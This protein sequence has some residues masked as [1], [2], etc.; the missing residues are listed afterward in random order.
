[1]SNRSLSYI[2]TR[3]TY[4]SFHIITH[5]SSTLIQMSHISMML[6][7]FFSPSCRQNSFPI[8]QV[9]ILFWNER[10]EVLN[11]SLR[12]TLRGCLAPGV[13]RTAHHSS[14]TRRQSVRDRLSARAHTLLPHS[15]TLW[16]TRGHWRKHTQTRSFGPRRK[17]RRGEEFSIG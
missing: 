12:A 14:P 8:L 7:G 3:V 9:F 1:M 15:H 17:E 13:V 11:A 6:W 4:I 16:N 2:Y 5:T 10:S